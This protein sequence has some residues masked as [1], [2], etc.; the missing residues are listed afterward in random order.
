MTDPRQEQN[1]VVLHSKGDG[2]GP[3][4]DGG[5]GMF[6]RPDP[7]CPVTPLGQ[8]GSRFFFTNTLPQ[9]TAVDARALGRPT[10]QLALRGGTTE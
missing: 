3:P 10:V 6:A 7:K 5:G 8:N 4:G 9:A 1:V 2:G